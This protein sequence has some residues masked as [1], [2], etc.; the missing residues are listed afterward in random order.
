VPAP[1]DGPAALLASMAART[2]RSRSTGSA[3]P[4]GR[5][6]RNPDSWLPPEPPRA[7]VLTGISA[8][9]VS[10]S[11]GTSRDR[12]HDRSPPASTASATSLVVPPCWRR[13]CR[14][15]ARSRRT[16]AT[17]RAEPPDVSMAGTGGLRMARATAPAMAAVSP[18]PSSGGWA[19]V[20]TGGNPPS[21][22]APANATAP[23]PSAS[24]WCS[25]TSTANF[26]SGRPV[27]TCTSHGG[28]VRSS[29]VASQPATY[30]SNV[31]R[32]RTAYPRTCAAGSK[33]DAGHHDGNQLPSTRSAGSRAAR[34]ATSSRS[35]SWDAGPRKTATAP[36][37]IGRRRV[38][39]LRNAASSPL[40]RPMAPPHQR[41]VTSALRACETADVHSFVQVSRTG[42]T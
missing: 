2:A 24:E 13:I 35:P 17:R 38:S 7:R 41:H 15:S 37:C 39:R 21:S 4:T 30:A 20:R 11:T 34:S 31:R 18:R 22:S 40:S 3:S 42:T 29:G 12:S 33:S 9:G 6:H 23:A 10:P 8:R 27:T 19:P 28:L 14:T 36:R 5:S 26:S 1:R 25:F 16:N 32:S